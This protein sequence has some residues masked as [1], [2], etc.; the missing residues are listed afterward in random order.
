MSQQKRYKGKEDPNKVDR[1][2]TISPKASIFENIVVS[3]LNR[4]Q[5]KFDQ[6]SDD[7]ID[8]SID[9]SCETE[10]QRLWESDTV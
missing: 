6:A 10:C 3:L 9:D 8:K 1:F 5:A 2:P 7:Q 4:C